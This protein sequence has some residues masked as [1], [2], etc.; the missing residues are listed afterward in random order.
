MATSTKPVAP[1]ASRRR[2]LWWRIVTAPIAIL[3]A[4]ALGLID[5]LWYPLLAVMVW[6][7]RL[8]AVRWLEQQIA[9]LPPY[10]ALLLF[11]VPAL[12]LLPFKFFGLYLIASGKG[13]A[14][15]GVFVLAKVVGTALFAWI[16]ALTSPAL[17]RLAWF[18]RLYDWFVPYK[19]R[20]YNAVFGHP[21][22][23]TIRAVSRLTRDR[24]RRWWRRG[25]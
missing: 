2:P 5:W 16:F 7:T 20:L 12:S 1:S 10:A 9:R 13:L 4:I 25:E 15:V 8:R 21:L 23:R 19:A 17:M 14:G 11:A 6:L 18:K 22:I 3:L 24:I